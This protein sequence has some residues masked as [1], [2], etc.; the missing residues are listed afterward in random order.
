MLGGR[1]GIAAQRSLYT[2][3]VDLYISERTPDG[4]RAMMTKCEFEVVEVGQPVAYDDFRPLMLTPDAA[5]HLI[6]Q[7]WNCGVRPTEGAG[8]AGAMLQAQDH[9]NTLKQECERLYALLK[10]NASAQ[11]G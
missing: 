1:I 7:L 9:I 8:S 5:Q 3:T 2:D 6:D 11:N 4:K 10:M